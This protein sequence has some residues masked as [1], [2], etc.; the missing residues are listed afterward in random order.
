MCGIAISLYCVCKQYRSFC[1]SP[2]I[3]H[4][5]CTD[6]QAEIASSDGAD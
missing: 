6:C 4:L 3:I 1:A 5:Q 2:I